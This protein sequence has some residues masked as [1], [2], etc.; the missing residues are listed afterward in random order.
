MHAQGVA[1]K[2]P[3]MFARGTPRVVAVLM[4][5]ALSFSGAWAQGEAGGRVQDQLDQTVSLSAAAQ[6][7][8]TQDW[9]SMRFMAKQDGASAAVVQAGLKRALADALEQVQPLAQAEALQVSTGRFSMQP[10]Y[11]SAGASMGWR[12]EAELVLEGND[13]AR[14]G[15]A[16]AR[17]GHLAITAVHWRVSAQARRAVADQLRAEA[18]AA[19]RAQALSVSQA[20]GFAGYRLIEAQVAD[21]SEGLRPPMMMARAMGAADAS[22][23]PVPAVAGTETLSVQVH[24]RIQLQ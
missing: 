17:L 7:Q 13:A 6:R 16:S 18:I 19:F 3:T 12:G 1:V 11:S 5:A 21:A 22:A 2:I 4:L 10:R 9:L 15:E 23:S 20:F 24:G 8:V 14:I